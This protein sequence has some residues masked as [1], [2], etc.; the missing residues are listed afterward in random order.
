MDPIF[1]CNCQAI[2]NYSTR[3]V[4]MVR[5]MESVIGCRKSKGRFVSVG[6]IIIRR[7]ICRP[8]G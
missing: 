8:A 2:A 3:I 6:G 1:S 4:E 7:E 5:V